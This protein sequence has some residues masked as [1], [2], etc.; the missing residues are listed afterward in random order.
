MGKVL[1]PGQ[2]LIASVE[3]IGHFLVANLSG[4]VYEGARLL[5]AEGIAE[6]HAP[7]VDAGDVSYAMGWVVGDVGGLPAVYHHG[8]TPNFHSTMLMEPG[9]RRGVVVATNEVT[10]KMCTT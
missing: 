1:T 4:G 9:G 7:A 10:P 3:D 2:D 8:S 5:S 6:L